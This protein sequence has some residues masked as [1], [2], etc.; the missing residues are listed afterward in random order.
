MIYAI[1][2]SF[3]TLELLPLTLSELAIIVQ[4]QCW[5]YVK[6]TSNFSQTLCLQISKTVSKTFPHT[7]EPLGVGEQSLN[8]TIILWLGSK[9]KYLNLQ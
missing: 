6:L 2:D 5:L 4:N 8:K 7:S 3:K 1:F 9:Y